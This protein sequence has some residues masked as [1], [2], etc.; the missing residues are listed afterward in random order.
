M[1]PVFQ[2]GDLTSELPGKVDEKG[3]KVGWLSGSPLAPRPAGRPAIHWRWE[4]GKSVSMEG[5]W[6]YAA[7]ETLAGNIL[8]QVMADIFFGIVETIPA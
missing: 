6:G 7:I 4:S 5:H 1:S 3:Q 8:E 2:A